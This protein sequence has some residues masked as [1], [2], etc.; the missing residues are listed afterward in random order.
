[1]DIL[2]ANPRG[3]CA[4]VDRAISIV[5]RA[6][7]IFEKPIYVRHEVVHNRCDHRRVGVLHR[8]G[9]AQ[10]RRLGQGYFQGLQLLLWGE[11][12]LHH[13]RPVRNRVHKALVFRRHFIYKFGGL[14]ETFYFNVPASAGNSPLN[15]CSSVN[16]TNN[17]GSFPS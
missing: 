11:E 15:L 7:D 3:F 12:V 9:F 17:V 16:D 10:H 5:E 4:G 6:L 1:M 13:L 14:Q 2:L 8:L